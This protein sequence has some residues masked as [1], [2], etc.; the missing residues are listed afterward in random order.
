MNTKQYL[1]SKKFKGTMDEFIKQQAEQEEYEDSSSHRV[2]LG[3]FD[4][5]DCDFYR[6]HFYN[7]AEQPYYAHLSHILKDDRG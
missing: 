4:E 5:R 3:T 6:S 1:K 7:V 2:H